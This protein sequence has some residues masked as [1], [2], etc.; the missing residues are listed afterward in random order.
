[1]Q[2]WRGALV[3]PILMTTCQRGVRLW[4]AQ[5]EQ[6]AFRISGPLAAYNR[7]QMMPNDRYWR[8]AAIG[9]TGDE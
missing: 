4:A 2:G 5:P 7:R 9:L 3:L 1:V 6:V 8:E